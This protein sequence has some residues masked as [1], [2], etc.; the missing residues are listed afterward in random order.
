[1]MLQ[2]LKPIILELCNWMEVQLPIG[3]DVESMIALSSLTPQGCKQ[4]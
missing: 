4:A 3:F 2:P 1:M